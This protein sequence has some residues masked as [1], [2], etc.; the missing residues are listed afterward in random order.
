[1]SNLYQ[2]PGLT[3]DWLNG[4]LAAI[5][6]TVLIPGLRLAWSNE[7]VPVAIFTSDGEID[8]ASS[9]GDELPTEN[10][11]ADSVIA[12]KHPA[13]HHEF[14]RNV[15]FAS[16][17]ERAA[18]E[19][20]TKTGFVAAS[21]SDLRFDLDQN[22]LDHSAFDPPAPRGETLWSRAVACAKAIASDDIVS[23]ITETLAGRGHRKKLNG[24]G[25]DA[26]RLPLGI[27]G[28][29]SVS[30]LFVDPLIELLCFSSLP[31]FPTRGNGRAIRQ[32]GWRDGN[33]KRGAF[34]WIAWTPS[35]DRWGIDALLD[36]EYETQ[37]PL[38]IAR[39]RVVPYQPLGSADVRRAYFA[40]RVS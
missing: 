38:A 22:N 29:G 24:L 31:L 10:S 2:A 12:K 33:L 16:F 8:L 27:H 6:V 19:R 26:K 30:D 4:W 23:S 20:T 21:V 35:L 32:R 3:A 7:P 18:L 25:F 14:G 5:G 11:L 34:E 36:L 1:M 17:Q 37:T 39:Y 9:L 15:T 28:A 13:A 40:E